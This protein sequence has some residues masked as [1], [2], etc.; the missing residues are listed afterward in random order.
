VKTK[1]RW[2]PYWISFCHDV[3]RA[4]LLIGG[5]KLEPMLM[6]RSQGT[7]EVKMVVA[8]GMLGLERPD[9]FL[10]RVTT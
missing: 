2:V 1:L 10:T 7:L 4:H 6:L 9:P 5:V 3:V 8:K